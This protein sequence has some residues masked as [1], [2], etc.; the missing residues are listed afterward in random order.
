M[1]GGAASRWTL[2]MAGDGAL[3]G[4]IYLEGS[5]WAGPEDTE[6]LAPV[7]LGITNGSGG[8]G[9]EGEQIQDHTPPGGSAPRC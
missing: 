7:S 6:A 9:S 1:H 5:T 3:C 8:R 2:T 4:F